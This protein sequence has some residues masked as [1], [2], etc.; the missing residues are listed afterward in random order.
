M[1]LLFDQNLSRRLVERLADVF[2]GSTH[3]TYLGLAEADDLAV[4][5]RA[6]TDGYAIISRDSD[7]NDLLILRGYPPHVIWVRRGN[8][9]TDEIESLL[10]SRREEIDGLPSSSN[11][12]LVIE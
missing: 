7:F 6:K 12:L 3:V 1:R 4:W 8:C 9:S 11:G 2:P 5:S 10:R